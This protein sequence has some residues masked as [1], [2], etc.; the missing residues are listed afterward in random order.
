M[1]KL[2][3]AILMLGLSPAAAKEPATDPAVMQA[4]DVFNLEYATD[5]QLSPDGRKI[6][7]VRR[8]FDIMA[9]KARSNIWLIDV[10]SGEQRPVLSSTAS[11]ASPHWS[12]DGKRLAYVSAVD[13]G[14]QV[15]VRWMDSGVTAR[16]TD[17]QR[18]PSSLVWAPSGKSIA[19]TM[20]V[21]DEGEP[22]AKMPSPPEGA[23]WAPSPKV[24]DRMQYRSDGEGYLEQGVNHVFVVAADG[25]TPRQVTTGRFNHNGTPAWSR[26]GRTIFISADR[27]DDWERTSG[28][29]EIWAVDVATGVARALTA[30]D[31]PDVVPRVSPDG[32]QIAYLRFTDN[33]KAN[34]QLELWVMNADGS[35]G[36]RLAT[37]LDREISDIQWSGNAAIVFSYD[38]E[39]AT[40]LGLAT[41]SG[42]YRTLAT[43]LGG[44]DLGRP[45]GAASFSVA[46][47]ATAFNVTTPREPA[48]IAVLSGGKVR[49]LTHLNDDITARRQLSDAEQMWVTAPDGTRS[50]AWI[51]KPPH[52]DPARKYPLILEIHGGPHANYGA[53]FTAELQ[54]YAAAG[55]VVLFTNPRGSTSYG[56]DFG[57][58]IDKTYP[59]GDYD[60]LMA[61]VDQVVARGYV[62]ADQ[63]YVTGGS[64]GGVLT[65]W[66]VGKT[67]RFRAAVVAKPVI[68]WTSF[69]LHSDSPAYFYK[70][71]FGKTPWADGAQ[72]AYWARSPLSLVGNV[73][74]PTMLLTGEADYRTPISESEQYYAAL[75][76]Q[77]VDS[78]MVRIPEASHGIVDR[79][80]RL[81]A[82]VNYILAW[83]AKHKV[84]NTPVAAA[85]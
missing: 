4:T 72:A 65:A 27:N 64:G 61:A 44:E 69:V 63:M 16:V 3:I 74:T 52:F 30:N 28:R 8:S 68:N 48:D 42:S 85:P 26:D 14:A 36:R 77:G 79:P 15:Y 60:D 71:W 81:I 51:L 45:Y 73:R 10:A 75:Q 78:A 70:Y 11:Y 59:G 50:E 13:G 58:M 1:R 25:S 66:I 37:N 21:P 54:L 7:Y 41:L 2:A 76:I 32:K 57:N 38:D 62:D 43:G 47:G 17:L 40:K 33:L 5:P 12:P 84:P 39:G 23:T 56:V 82:K 67:D 31:G 29:P 22:F 20:F 46:G 9:D 18:A 55:Y 24:I 6:A 80:S 49:R 83:F 35:G 34:Q 19:F 53:R